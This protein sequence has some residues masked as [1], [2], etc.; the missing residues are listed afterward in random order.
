LALGARLNSASAGITCCVPDSRL[1]GYSEAEARKR[2]ARLD[3]SG[4]AVVRRQSLT[5]VT[6]DSVLMRQSLR[7][8]IR[9]FV[10]TVKR[11]LREVDFIAEL[12]CDVGAH[13]G[14]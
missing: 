8:Y 9:P 5:N 11:Y 13:R 1:G 12:A 14:N 10:S 6:G 4:R 7:D 2:K 3:C